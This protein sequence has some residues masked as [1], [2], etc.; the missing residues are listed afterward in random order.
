MQIL[1]I[2]DEPL[3][4]LALSENLKKVFCAADDTVVAFDEAA[5]VLAFLESG[6]A[7]ADFAF[8]DVKLRGMLG[9]DLAVEIRK[10][11]PAVRIIFCTAYAGFTLDAFNVYALGYL[12]KPITEEKIRN[13]LHQLELMLPGRSHARLRVQAFGHFAAF[14]QGKPLHWYRK[15]AEELFAFLVDRRGASVSNSEIAM[16][17]W[18]DDSK[19]RNVQTILS[20]LR[21]TLKEA[22]CE[23]VLIHTRNRTAVDVERIDCDYYDYLAGDPSAAGEYQ[24]EYMSNYSWA[25]FTNGRLYTARLEEERAYT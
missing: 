7:S 23:D 9:I 20:S 21:Q 14:Y 4:L 5:D 12:L 8:L 10:K 1:A 24:G 17:L 15:K 16:I 2:D 13:V 6:A 11:C 22:G 3:M 25:E 19:V 18:E